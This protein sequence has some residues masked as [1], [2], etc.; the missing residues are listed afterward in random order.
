MRIITRDFFDV[1]RPDIFTIADIGD[2]HIGAAACDE[3][4]LRDKV[5][6]IAGDERCYWI[7]LG[8]YCDFINRSDPRFSPGSLAKWITMADLADLA[9]AQ[10]DRFLDIVKPIAGKCLALVEGNHETAITK[11]YERGIYSEIVTAIKQFAGHPDDYK[12]GVGYN[13]WLILNFYRSPKGKR[14]AQSSKISINLHHGFGGGK[15]AGGKALNLERW[16][17]NHECDIAIL[18]HTH[19]TMTIT[20]ARES[21]VGKTVQHKKMLGVIGGTFLGSFNQ[22]G[23]STY[24]EVNGYFPL[25]LTSVEIGLRPHAKDFNDRFW[26]VTI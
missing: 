23:P 22:D 17:W 15:L 6:R 3:K 5:D 11:H 21:V 26:A 25:P 24:S 20:G 9:A 12:L 7:G 19:N 13:G 14:L 4:R 1:T 2:V 8:D 18:G 10:R 16:L